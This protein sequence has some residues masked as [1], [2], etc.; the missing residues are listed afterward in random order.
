MIHR[1]PDNDTRAI[2]RLLVNLRFFS[3]QGT[4]TLAQR[5]LSR[6]SE[7]HGRSRLICNSTVNVCALANFSRS[8]T[9]SRDD[10]TPL[11]DMVCVMK[12]YLE[13]T[14]GGCFVTQR[15][16]GDAASAELRAWNWS[17][18]PWHFELTTDGVSTMYYFATS[19]D[20]CDSLRLRDIGD[21]TWAFGLAV[22]SH[23]QSL[24]PGVDSAHVKIDEIATN[25]R[26]V[27]VPALHGEGILLW[28]PV[29]Q[30]L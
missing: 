8:A 10:F 6:C 15:G 27:A 1:L 4:G 14:A 11:D 7:S 12:D 18:P 30:R 23:S 29:D 3:A 25:A 5:L 28:D 2:E 24:H 19:A 13:K 9:S 26:M 21:M 17:P 22:F 20:A 16:S